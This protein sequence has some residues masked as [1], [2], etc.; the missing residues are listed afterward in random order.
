MIPATGE[1]GG[2][3]SALAGRL[4]RC[5]RKLDRLFADLRSVREPLDPRKLCTV[6]DVHGQFMAMIQ[7]V[8]RPHQSPRSFASKYMHF[9]CPAVPIIDQYA[10]EA[11]NKLVRWRKSHSLSDLP[12]DRDE[13]YARYVQRF[14]QLYRTARDAMVEPTV[15]HFD[16]YLICSLRGASR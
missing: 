12:N 10:V 8:L 4:L 7:P 6:L 14:W 13:A 15:R 2:S 11:C 5:G 1:Q 9:H 3:M 16:Y